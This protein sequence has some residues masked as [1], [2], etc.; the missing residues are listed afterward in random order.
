MILFSRQSHNTAMR[1]PC[2]NSTQ[3]ALELHAACLVT[4]LSAKNVMLCN[5]KFIQKRA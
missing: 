3:H 4:D 2:H 5:P 1:F